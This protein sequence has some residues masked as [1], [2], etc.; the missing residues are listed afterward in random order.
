MPLPDEAFVLP[1]VM[2]PAIAAVLGMSTWDT[3][4]I[5]RVLHKAG[6]AVVRR[7]EDERTHAL[8]FALPYAIA[9][10]DDWSR[11]VN[12]ALRSIDREAGQDI[13]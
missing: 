4:Q 2:T 8:F 1:R 13:P 10:G 5:A 6:H 12:E 11:H 7:P 9:F 3:I